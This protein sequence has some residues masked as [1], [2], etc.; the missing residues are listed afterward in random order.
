MFRDVPEC[1]RMFHVPGF[2]DGQY[3]GTRNKL[4]IISFHNS[5]IKVNRFALQ[6]LFF[7]LP[8][9]TLSTSLKK[10]KIVKLNI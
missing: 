5:Q 7:S 4:I 8:T 2:I 9:N 3:E 6:V 10:K 1:S